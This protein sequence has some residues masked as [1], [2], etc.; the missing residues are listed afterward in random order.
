MIF[1]SNCHTCWAIASITPALTTNIHQS[2]RS[3]KGFNTAWMHLEVKLQHISDVLFK[4][5]S[6][7]VCIFPSSNCLSICR[8]MPENAAHAFGTTQLRWGQGT[9]PRIRYW[10]LAYTMSSNSDQGVVPSFTT[11]VACFTDRVRWRSRSTE[12]RN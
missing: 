10:F 12:I 8:T 7:E 4:W 2:I 3:N 6:I 11:S 5:I 1:S 9:F